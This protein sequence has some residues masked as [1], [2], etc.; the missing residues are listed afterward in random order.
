M[1]LDSRLVA[2]A[3]LVGR[4][5][6]NSVSLEHAHMVNRGSTDGYYEVAKYE[7]RGRKISNRMDEILAIIMQDNAFQREAENIMAIAFPSGSEPPL[8]KIDTTT[9]QTVQ[10]VP[11]TAPLGH[12]S[13]HSD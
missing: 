8:A 5:A 6:R 13:D 3:E 1:E 7:I 4:Y 10:S 9:T 2:Y 12:H 11:S